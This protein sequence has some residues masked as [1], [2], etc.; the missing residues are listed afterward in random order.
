MAGAGL[1][2]VSFL[3][4]MGLTQAQYFLFVGCFYRVGQKTT[5]KEKFVAAA[6]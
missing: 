3:S 4:K 6:G 1:F 5:D 2:T